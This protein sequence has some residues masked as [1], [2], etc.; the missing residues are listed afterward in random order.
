MLHSWPVRTLRKKSVHLKTPAKESLQVDRQ[1]EVETEEGFGIK[2]AP[3][4]GVNTFL[5]DTTNDSLKVPSFQV[6][7]QL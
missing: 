7:L 5:E 6:G 2:T 3:Y 4:P 1:I